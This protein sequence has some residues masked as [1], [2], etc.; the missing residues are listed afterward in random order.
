MSFQGLALFECFITLITLEW[1]LSRVCSLVRQEMGILGKSPST[2]LTPKPQNKN[3]EPQNKNIET[4]S[5]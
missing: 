1:L 2:F 4:Y 3:I 5:N